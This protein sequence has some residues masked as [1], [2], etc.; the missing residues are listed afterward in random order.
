MAVS[1]SISIKQNSQNIAN[2]TSSI[3][4]TG[5]ATMSGPSYDYYTRTGTLTI[6]GKDYSFSA[7]FPENTTKTLFSKTVTVTHNSVG[8]KTVS[9]SFS[10]KTG[11]TGTLP[12]G[13]ISKSTSKKLTTIPRTSK[14][15][16]SS[17]N[18]YIGSTITIN[19]NRAS[20]SFTHTAVIKFN[21]TTVRTQTNIGASYSWNTSELYAKIPNANRGTG[22][23]T[24]TTYSGNTNIGSS[25]VNFTANVRNSNPTFSNFDVEDTNAT[26][27]ALTGDSTK[28]VKKYSNAKVTITSANKMTTKNSAT[29]KSYNV[30]AGSASKSL[31]YSSSSTVTTTINNVNSNTISVYAIDS[32]NNQTSVTKSL[33][34]I[35]YTEVLLQSIDVHRENGIGTSVIITANGKY[36]NV[37]FGDV[38]N[39]IKTIQFRKKQSSSSTWGSW[40]SIKYLF[41]IDTTNG[42]F[43]TKETLSSSS[44]SGFRLGVEYDVQI[45]VTDELSEDVEE[46]QVNSGKVLMS[47]VK[48]QGVCFGGIY[49]DD[50][51]GYLQVGESDPINVEDAVKKFNCINVTTVGTDLNDYIETGRYFFNS[52]NKPENIPAG[53]NG[54]LE[55]ISSNDNTVK[56]IWY[57]Y[58]TANSNDYQTFI[59]TKMSTTWSNWTDILS[60]HDSGWQTVTLT[61]DFKPYNNN[62][63]NTPKYIKVGRMVE[64]L[65]EI[66]PNK[67]FNKE[68]EYTMF[69]LPSGYRPMYEFQTLCQGTGANKWLLTTST[70]GKFKFARYGTTEYAVPSTSVWLTFHVV[71]LTS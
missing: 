58:G 32:R 47:A 7:T 43:E 41:D 17:T 42:T 20:S 51:G 11:M 70:D 14:V 12:N 71:F 48:D 16:M 25:S 40:Q 66:S 8:E 4:V 49:D 23:V 36:D 29:A 18:F 2:N 24:L 30:V 21:G 6:D 33:D 38:T 59:R 60:G 9:A 26:V 54:W 55:V 13:V 3:T 35:D 15:S 19:T 46:V 50:V 52:A 56:Q 1:G 28:Y 45:K 27:L 67:T 39:S 22:T 37:D 57:R 34:V 63:D 31:D 44:I 61:S 64:V 68:S 69:T 10:I 65:G 62:T 53:V 5:T